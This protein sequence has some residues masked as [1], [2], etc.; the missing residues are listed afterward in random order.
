MGA[1]MLPL[2]GWAPDA[3]PTAPGVI[4]DCSNLIPS[5]RGMVAA[6]TATAPAGVGVLAADARGAAVTTSTTGTR[7]VLVGTQTRLYELSGTTY[8]DVTRAAGV[9][10]GAADNRWS[11]AQFGNATVATNDTDAMQ[12]STSGVFA[13]IS[14]AP[15]AR[16]VCAA[17][18]FVIA[19][20]TSDGT[21]G[22][23]SDR[24]WCSAINDHTSWTP[25]VTTQATTGRLIGDGGE[26][27]AAARLGQQVVAYKARSM[28]L[29]TY[30][31]APVVWQWDQVPGEL[32]CVGP[33]AV[34]DIGGAHIFVGD[35]N[36]WL[37]DGTRPVPIAEGVVRRWFFDNSSATYRFRTIVSMDRQSNRVWIFF[38][39]SGSGTGNPDRAIVYH[40]A[41][42][43]WGRADNA[44]QCALAY[45]GSGTTFDGAN[46]TFNSAP[47]V[48]MDSP[49]W[50][51]GGRV[52]AAITSGRQ[53]V[54]LT[55]T[56]GASTL[57]TGDIGDD[58]QVT[59][60]R[61]ARLRFTDDPTS[62]NAQGFRRQGAGAALV[63]A[64]SASRNDTGFDLRQSGRWHRV[65]FTMSGD[66]E[67]TGMAVDITAAGRR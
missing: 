30:V 13:D 56:V 62:A 7:R 38:P 35:D 16:V 2:I 55:G 23:Q 60:L 58:E 52:A 61:R 10:V 65:T 26:I 9:Y 29:G 22:D 45:V 25:S 63:A 50:L 40:L 24:W 41:K 20:N 44:V 36:I 64:A 12:A 46:V 33:E 54:T 59:M 6:P 27:T 14:G 17:A 57:T 66:Y 3:D 11:F 39:S 4:A 47:A 5:E 43:T 49:Y 8:T 32:G 48:S 1:P 42:K 53:L 18:N 37:Y 15:K 51:A 31:G 67:V 19:F 34:V 21:Y 28:F